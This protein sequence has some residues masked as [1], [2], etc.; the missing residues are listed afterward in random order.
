MSHGG[1]AFGQSPSLNFEVASIKKNESTEAGARVDVQPS[2]RVIWTNLPISAFVLGA[3]GLPD[4][5]QVVGVPEWARTERYDIVAKAPEGVSLGAAIASGTE[6]TPLQQMQRSLLQERFSFSAH[7][8][9]RELAGY[10]LLRVTPSGPL[11]PNLTPSR[12]DCVALRAAQRGAGTLPPAPGERR[13]CG[14]SG[15]AGSFSGGG[16]TV[17]QFVMMFVA[18]R[19]GKPVVDRTDLLGTY[20]VFLT[21]KPNSRLLDG[22]SSPDDTEAPDWI[23]AL[24]E[25][26][27]LKIQSTTTLSDVLVIDRLDRPTAD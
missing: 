13:Q 25:Q 5:F 4:L 7:V 27:S 20:D 8:E 21:F 19:L 10:A 23:T 11:G 24:K 17:A 26:L 14:M 18:P 9:Q 3:Y 1:P 12:T 6:P 16:I 15:T 22:A 2:G